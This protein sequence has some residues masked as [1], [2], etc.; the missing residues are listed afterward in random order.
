MKKRLTISAIMVLFLLI[1]SQLVWI[2]Q[3]AE[4]DKSRFKD[5]VGNSIRD[6]VK[7]Q[8]AKQTFDLLGANVN[9]PNITLERVDI[10]SLHTNEKIYG[11]IDTKKTDTDLPLSHFLEAAI[12]ERLFDNNTLNLQT[13]DTLFQNK[14]P[15]TTELSAYS[16][17]MQE[18]SITTDSLYSGT[19]AIKQLNDTTKG[20]YITMPLGTSGNYRFISHFIFKP[21]TATQRMTILVIISAVAVVAVAIIFFVLLYQLQQQ[22]YRL[23]FQEKRARG[24]VHD[25]K[26]PLNYVFSILDL[27]ELTEKSSNKITEGKSRIK[28]LISNIERMLSEVEFNGKKSATL[29]PGFYD[30]TQY[31]RE[32]SND[33]GAIHNE[34]AITITTDIAPDADIIFVDSFYFDSCLRNLLE[35]AIK[36][37]DNTPIITITAKKERKN[38]VIAITDQGQGI[39]KKEQRKIFRDFYR[40]PRK[41]TGKGYG[42][43][44]STVQ[45]IVK[46]HGGR[47]KLESK[48][49]RRSVFTITIPHKIK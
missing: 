28:Q 22:L 18:K 1:A 26:S 34:K 48:E 24:I 31:C 2:G 30:L 35:N 9:S 6:I 23:Q 41:S 19:K 33:L 10:D 21:T 45:Q 20:I 38:I 44:L 16:F 12:T 4:R 46:A 39:P 43:G 42:I 17:E 32:L 27:F 15:Y 29:K 5:E 37:S 49:E 47:I 36:Y 25:L 14:F 11:N 8:C 13:V 7:Y 40:S 3:V